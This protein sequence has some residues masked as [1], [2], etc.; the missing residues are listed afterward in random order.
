MVQNEIGWF[1]NEI[2]WFKNK[3]GWF[4]MKSDSSKMKSDGSKIK[5]DG[6]KIKSDGSKIKSDGSTIKSDGSKIKSDVM[7]TSRPVRD[8][9]FVTADFNRRAASRFTA[10]VS[11]RQHIGLFVLSRRNKGKCLVNCPPI[12]IGSYKY[13]VPNGTMRNISQ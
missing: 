12:K 13:S 2:G 1:K 3:I 4:K 5:S 11:E 10:F 9:I 7:Q 8:A 6:S